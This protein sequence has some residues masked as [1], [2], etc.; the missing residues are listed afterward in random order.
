MTKFDF[1]GPRLTVLAVNLPSWS[2]GFFFVDGL[3]KSAAARPGRAS[4]FKVG[5][6]KALLR[7]ESGRAAGCS[8]WKRD[9]DIQVWKRDFDIQ[10]WKRDFD[11]QVW[12]RDFDIQVWKRDFDISKFQQKYVKGLAYYTVIH[13]KRSFE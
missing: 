7:Q 10:V 12:K 9:F 3:I 13:T 6:W 2:D 8:V 11:I 1:H 5:C 4:V